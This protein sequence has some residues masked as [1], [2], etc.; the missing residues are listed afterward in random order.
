MLIRNAAIL[1][2]AGKIDTLVLDKTGTLTEGRPSVVEFSSVDDHWKILLSQLGA[3]TKCSEHPLS[4]AITAYAEM[5]CGP[6]DLAKDFQSHTGQGVV[7]KIDGHSVVV[8]DA[9]FVSS[10]G[11]MVPPLKNINKGA[12]GAGR[13]LVL[14]AL[15]QRVVAFFVVADPLRETAHDSIRDLKALGLRVMMLTGD[16]QETAYAIGRRVGIVPANVKALTL[17]VRSGRN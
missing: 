6:L 4:R 10:R 2:R 17:P 9:S 7:G 12:E 11:I 3:V 16:A 1:E 8:G 13:T 5:E 14:A 15:D